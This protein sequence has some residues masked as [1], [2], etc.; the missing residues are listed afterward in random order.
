MASVPVTAQQPQPPAQLLTLHHGQEAL[1][2][3]PY[4]PLMAAGEG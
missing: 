1:R 3:H 2:P 4:R